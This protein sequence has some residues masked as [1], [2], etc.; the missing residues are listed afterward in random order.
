MPV[1][2]HVQVWRICRKPLIQTE[3]YTIHNIALTE[4]G[5]VVHNCIVYVVVVVVTQAIASMS[6]HTHKQKPEP[7]FSPSLGQGSYR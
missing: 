5:Y 7:T 1:Y 2:I 6:T 4:E 3:K